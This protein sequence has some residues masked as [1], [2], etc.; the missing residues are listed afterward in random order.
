VSRLPEPFRNL[1]AEL[2]SIRADIKDLQRRSAWTGSGMTLLGG[3]HTAFTP[4]LITND[5]LSSPA[6]PGVAGVETTNFS[7]GTT[8]AE[9]A[10][11]NLSVPT[12]VTRLLVS[13]TAHVFALDDGGTSA[14][15][16]WV[17]LNAGGTSS[18]PIGT[19]WAASDFT[20]ASCSLGASLT[21]LTPGGV[22]RLG[23]WAGASAVSHDAD[24]D[25]T[26]ALT[27]SLTWAP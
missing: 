7:V 20:T 21:G 15:A 17:S 22:V 8:L 13:A 23:V 11:L 24:V 18:T 9:V 14:D 19:P 25:N 4:G 6:I 16:R 3:G 2:K 10:G 1:T 12:G 5:S 26:A 27:A